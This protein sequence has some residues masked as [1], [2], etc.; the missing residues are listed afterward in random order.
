M[1]LN[2]RNLLLNTNRTAVIDAN[3]MRDHLYP[4][5]KGQLAKTNTECMVKLDSRTA[6]NFFAVLAA[7]LVAVCYHTRLL[8]IF[9]QSIDMAALYRTAHHRLNVAHMQGKRRPTAAHAQNLFVDLCYNRHVTATSTSDVPK[10]FQELGYITSTRANLHVPFKFVPSA[11][12]AVPT[13]PKP[14][15]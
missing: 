2:F 9:V 11:M 8:A 14:K 12:P 13:K 10:V 15:A 6:H 5:L 3:Y 1:I 4:N 7:C